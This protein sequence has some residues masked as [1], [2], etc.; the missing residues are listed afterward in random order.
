MISYYTRIKVNE[1]FN[2]N[3]LFN[4]VLNWLDTTRN[5]M[6]G[7]SFNGKLPFSYETGKKKLTFDW[8]KQHNIYTIQFVTKDNRKNA[9]FVVEAMVDY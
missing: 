8:F 2:N 6:E 4:M 7:L 9:Q 3:I 1:H 5:K